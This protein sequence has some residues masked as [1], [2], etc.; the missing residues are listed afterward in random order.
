MAPNRDFLIDG[1]L[2]YLLILFQIKLLKV[3]QG[4]AFLRTPA[5]HLLLIN[6]LI[7]NYLAARAFA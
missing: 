4:L 6:N 2:I 3:P 1:V 7:I 5:K